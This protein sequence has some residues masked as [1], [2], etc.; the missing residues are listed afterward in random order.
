LTKANFENKE[1]YL[2]EV[3]QVVR[4]LLEAWR[5]ETNVAQ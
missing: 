4:G 3:N 2:D 1:E 5:D